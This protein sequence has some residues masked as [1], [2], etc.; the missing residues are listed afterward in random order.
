MKKL[1]ILFLL[2]ATACTKDS[3]EDK[4]SRLIE[5]RITDANGDVASA[6]FTYDQ[7]GR[8]NSYSYSDNTIHVKSAT[9]TYTGNNI[10]ISFKELV[11][12]EITFNSTI[13]YIC[14]DNK[15]PIQRI[16]YD[17]LHVADELEQITVQTD[18]S[19]YQYD[20]SGLLLTMDGVSYDTTR[21]SAASEK[22]GHYSSERHRYNF[23]YSNSGNLIDHV[24]VSTN[25]THAQKDQYGEHTDA[26]YSS[27]KY[28]IGYTQQYP[29]QID[30]SNAFLLS[31]FGVIYP[32]RFPLNSA[33]GL[34]PDN[35]NLTQIA[36]SAFWLMKFN[37]IPLENTTGTESWILNYEK[38]RI[39]F[40]AGSNQVTELIYNKR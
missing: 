15:M 6:K 17:S 10:L 4:E 27:A 32:R 7:M 26:D 24:T 21:F 28:T 1:I 31:E 22:N 16:Q 20:A 38:G 12:N 34:L 36:G 2:F 9:I 13:R 37:Y 14:N 18:T 5:A 39:I 19:H 11:Q 8:M 30:A 23:A 25:V 33:Y 3:P 35:I 40:F 29:N